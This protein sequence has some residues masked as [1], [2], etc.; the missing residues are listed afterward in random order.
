MV[1][2]KFHISLEEEEE[3]LLL[4]RL[5]NRLREALIGVK[6]AVFTFWWGRFCGIC[7][8]TASSPRLPGESSQHVHKVDRYRGCGYLHYSSVL[9]AQ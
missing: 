6:S 1:V 7:N 2:G 8:E 3:D 5:H 4:L 9:L